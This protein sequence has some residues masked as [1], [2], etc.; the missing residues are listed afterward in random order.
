[1]PWTEGGENK[2]GCNSPNARACCVESR[3]EQKY[4]TRLL[5]RKEP[6]P[7]KW[8]PGLLLFKKSS[9]LKPFGWRQ[10]FEILWLILDLDWLTTLLWNLNSWTFP[11]LSCAYC[12]GFEL[13][14]K[15]ILLDL[16]GV[17]FVCVCLCVRFATWKIYFRVKFAYLSMCL[18]VCGLR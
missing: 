8:T 2:W 14:L 18:W 3:G 7:S 16:W 15:A 9:K 5:P 17:Y 13:S 11:D 6:R 1:M 4:S 10:Q 12:F